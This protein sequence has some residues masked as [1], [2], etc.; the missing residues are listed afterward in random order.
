[1][2]K[3]KRCLPVAVRS[4]GMLRHEYTAIQSFT[5]PFLL[6]T[7]F[8]K[9]KVQVRYGNWKADITCWSTVALAS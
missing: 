8:L 2:E 5:V 4:F 3:V 1:M 6:Q 9:S 7:P